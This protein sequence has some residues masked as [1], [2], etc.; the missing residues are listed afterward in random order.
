[1]KTMAKNMI[2]NELKIRITIKLNYAVK[3]GNLTRKRL[4]A[5]K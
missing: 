4:V 1:M 5:T 2:T 3:I